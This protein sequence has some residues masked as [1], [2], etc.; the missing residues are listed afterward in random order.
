MWWIFLWTIFQRLERFQ[1]KNETDHQGPKLNVPKEAEIA[2]K[3]LPLPLYLSWATCS[4]FQKQC[5]RL[6]WLIMAQLGGCTQ[7]EWKNSICL[8]KR[9]RTEKT[10]AEFVYIGTKMWRKQKVYKENSWHKVEYCLQI[11]AHV[12]LRLFW[13]YKTLALYSNFHSINVFFAN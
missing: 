9:S 10:K 5:Q 12:T 3:I 1:E 7:C 8:Q 4:C 11:S 6:A 13:F 2:E